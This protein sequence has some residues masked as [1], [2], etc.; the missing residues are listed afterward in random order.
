MD[1]IQSQKAAKIAYP[2]NIWGPFVTHVDSNIY[3]FYELYIRPSK[4]NNFRHMSLCNT[5]H[6]NSP[7]DHHHPYG[8]MP[9]LLC[10]A[11]IIDNIAK[12][13][14]TNDDDAQ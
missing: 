1:I 12:P 3:E 9:P 5:A 7:A 8:L 13:V 14:N 10:T 4:W 11:T 2:G 6:H